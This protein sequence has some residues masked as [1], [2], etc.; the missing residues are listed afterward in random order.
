MKK[1]MIR[2]AALSMA[3][4]MMAASLSGCG[5]RAEA[6]NQEIENGE[7][8][9]VTENNTPSD[10]EDEITSTEIIGGNDEAP[11]EFASAENEDIVLY[12]EI[13]T[14]QY[15]GQENEIFESIDVAFA[16]AEDI[17]LFNGRGQEVGYLK[18]GGYVA[19]TE[20]VPT[21]NWARF[22]NPIA[23]TDYDYLYINK[24]NFPDED[25]VIVTAEDLKQKIV[26]QMNNRAY[27]LPV[28][29]EEPAADMEVFEFRM[30]KEYMDDL[31][32][33]YWIRQCCEDGQFSLYNYMTYYVE[34]QDDGDGIIC[35]VYYKDLYEDVVGNKSN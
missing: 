4:T 28:I 26:E 11:A 33:N 14:A 2:I 27:E 31:E 20:S 21:N 25:V 7:T 13:G 34:C 5:A 16:A 1:K 3:C 30:E 19:V 15:I 23:G 18:E 22:E 29:L 10:S 24:K 35:K 8:I 9:I 17:P 32:V 12:A 6:T